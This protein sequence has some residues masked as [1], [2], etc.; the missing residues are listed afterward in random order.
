MAGYTYPSPPKDVS[1]EM[2]KP[3]PQ[4]TREVRNVVLTL[5]FFGIL[6]FLVLGISI[7]LTLLLGFIGFWLIYSIHN[8]WIIII[9]LGIAGIGVMVFVFVIKFLFARKV[10]DNSSRREITEE[11]YPD[12][13]AFIRRVSEETHT[14]FPKRIYL[15]P[16]VNAA[17]FYDS[18]FWSM[19]LPVR[20]NL[21]IGLGLVNMTNLSEFKSVI[22]HEFGHFSQKSMRAGS[23]VYHANKVLYNMLYENTGYVN[24][25]QGWANIHNIFAFCANITIK[26]VQS[27]QWILQQAYKVVNKQ[28]M[29][30]SRQMEFHADAMSAKVAGSNN[31]IHALRRIEFGDVCY[32]AVI[33]RYNQWLPENL[34][35]KN[36]FT[37]QRITASLIASDYK[38]QLSGNLPLLHEADKHYKNFSRIKVGEQWASHPP[39]EQREAALN[40]LNVMGTVVDEPVWTLFPDAAILQE[41]FTEQLYYEVS[42]TGTAMPLEDDLFKRRHEEERNRYAYP[43]FYNGY[44]NGRSITIFD[45][46]APAQ[47]TDTIPDIHAFFEQHGDSHDRMEA[48]R[49]DLQ[50]LDHIS[51]RKNGIRTF[52]FDGERYKRADAPLIRTTL[53]GILVKEEQA[54]KENDERVYHYYLHRAASRSADSAGI[55]KT[56]YGHYF[57]FRKLIA[58]NIDQ[59]NQLRDLLQSFYASSSREMLQNINIQLLEAVISWKAKLAQIQKELPLITGFE[60]ET[61]PDE[62]IALDDVSFY[63]LDGNNHIHEAHVDRLWAGVQQFGNW[64]FEAIFRAQ[65]KLLELQADIDKQ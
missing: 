54:L 31:A 13:F 25:L 57:E 29:S 35:G 47:L 56:A 42:F 20:K 18:G 50:L 63:F 3:S 62:L 4:F 22:A 65:K 11:E 15:S 34:K 51:D 43:L 14:R 60:Q 58:E 33:E 9:G 59:C 41:S 28:Y 19:L 5:V 30:L 64:T 48:I 38:L 40:L 55:L 44:Y 6:Y 37:Q 8:I 36:I 12:L 52:D 24:A 39:R 32:H 1:D 10:E 7:A 23:Y 16:E 49:N 21:V 2:I 17:V 46:T 61:L 26:I 27:I 53:E 45:I